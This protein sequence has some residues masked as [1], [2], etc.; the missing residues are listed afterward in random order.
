MGERYASN[1]AKDSGSDN[2]VAR[3]TRRND[4]PSKL[5]HMTG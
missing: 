2:P 5:L 3:G 4:M 1:D